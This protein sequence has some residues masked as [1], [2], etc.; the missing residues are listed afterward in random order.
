M[1]I[2][3]AASF[4][5]AWLRNPRTISAVTP[6]GSRVSAL[7]T[8]GIGPATGPVMELGPGTG[9]FTYSLLQ[10]GVREEDLTLV[11]LSAD[12]AALLRRRFPKAR[13]LCLDAMRIEQANVFADVSFGAVVSGLGFRAMRPLEIRAILSGAFKNLRSGGAFHQITY[14]PRCPVPSQV[15]DLLKLAEVRI[16]QTIWNLPPASVYRISRR[17]D[18]I[19]ASGSQSAGLPV[20]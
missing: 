5:L 17:E 16:G 11:E 19:I 3:D 15:L 20:A 2:T 8:Q 7:M 6:S 1:L 4:F 10:R 13:V 18:C 9:V 12:F 14:G